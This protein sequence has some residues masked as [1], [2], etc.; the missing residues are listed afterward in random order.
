MMIIPESRK[1][2]MGDEEH[3]KHLSVT[4]NVDF[5]GLPL[6]RLGRISLRE[7]RD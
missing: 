5:V 3:L 1:S 6:S 4:N 2:R 7:L